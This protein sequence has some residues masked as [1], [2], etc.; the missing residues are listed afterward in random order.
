MK[1]RCL[2][3]RSTAAFSLV[4]VVIALGVTIFCLI[5]LFGLL[6]VGLR[7]NQTT[8]EQGGAS[9]VLSAVIS[10]LYATPVTIPSGGATNSLQF[11]I[12]IPANPV[13]AATPVTTLYFAGGSLTTNSTAANSAYRL[14]VT[15]I[16]TVPTSA[17][18]T[19]TFLDLTVTWP[20]SVSVANASGSVETFVSL[21]RN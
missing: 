21:N 1:K 15:P 9:T 3:A 18:R 8:I 10:D 16:P 19:A 4:E 5:A 6:S 20:A 14:T 12:Q 17:V 7:S 11:N 2:N 13:A